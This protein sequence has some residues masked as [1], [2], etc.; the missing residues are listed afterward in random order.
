[1]KLEGLEGKGRHGLGKGGS[2]SKPPV[3]CLVTGDPANGQVWK[4][5]E[6][7]DLCVCCPCA[8]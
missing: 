8:I 3:E 1:M 5:A 7:N 4:C 2:I 6:N